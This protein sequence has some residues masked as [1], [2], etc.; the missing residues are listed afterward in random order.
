MIAEREIELVYDWIF[1]YAGRPIRAGKE[2]QPAIFYCRFINGK[3]RTPKIA[4]V[5]GDFSPEQRDTCVQLLLSMVAS[6]NYDV[7][8]LVSEAWSLDMSGFTK[9]EVE[10]YYKSFES[11]ADCPLRHEALVIWLYSK[12]HQWM[13]SSRIERPSNAVLRGP[14]IGGDDGNFEGRFARSSWTRPDVHR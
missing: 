13:A 11:L 12:E 1:D 7:A 8:G 2:L 14:L 5:P 10:A 9:E 4:P 3:L 6:P